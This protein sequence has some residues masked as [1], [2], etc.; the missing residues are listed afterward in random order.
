VFTGIV[1]EVGRI[2]ATTPGTLGVACR[3]V[4]EG[5]RVGDSIS[6]NG[7]CL[8]VAGL[9]S[10]HFTAEVMPETLRRTA[11]GQ[12]RPGDD[13]NLE[14]ALAFG[15]RLGG[16]FVQGHVEAVGRILS[17][18]P[19]GPALVVRVAAP[20]SVMR[21]TVQKGFIAVDGISLTVVD[22]GADYFTVA[23]AGFTREHTALAGKRPG[24]PVN[25]ESDV[26]AKYVERLTGP[27]PGGITREFLAEHG[28][29][30]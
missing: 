9:G 2:S 3:Q 23:L 13:V 19:D 25:L 27:R 22:A 4:L 26:L 5:T 18:T 1:E 8:T 14:R 15:A 20:D 10:G 12:L 16:H 17:Q 6:V 7:A 11:L 28:F 24:V 21:Y 30:S 29:T